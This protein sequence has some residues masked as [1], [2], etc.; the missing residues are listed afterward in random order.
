MWNILFERRFDLN[1]V[2]NYQSAI[3]HNVRLQSKPNFVIHWCNAKKKQ[4]KS[5]KVKIL[6]INKLVKKKNWNLNQAILTKIF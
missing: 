4:M 3:K 6:R 2:I 1:S 5:C